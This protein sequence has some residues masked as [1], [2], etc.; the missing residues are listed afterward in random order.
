MSAP[1][2]VKITPEQD[3]M[4]LSL[5]QQAAEAQ[6]NLNLFCAVVFRGVGIRVARNVQRASSPDGPRLVAEVQDVP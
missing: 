5:A 1:V 6:S 4:Y 3:E 2:E